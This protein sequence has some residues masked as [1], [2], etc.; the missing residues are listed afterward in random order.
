M[1]YVTLSHFLVNHKQVY[2]NIF[3]LNVPPLIR[4]TLS[5]IMKRVRTSNCC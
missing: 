5:E 1:T 4:A 2:N 3:Q